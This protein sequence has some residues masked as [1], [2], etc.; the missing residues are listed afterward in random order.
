[1]WPK[2]QAEHRRISDALLNHSQS[3]RALPGITSKSA[4]DTLAM[5]FIA[6]IRR[7]DYY[8]LVQR[9]DVDASK[10]DPNSG[11]FD[12]ERA[13]TYHIQN[14]NIEEAAWLIF[15]MTE[16]ARPASGWQRL[17]DVYGK[18]GTGIWDWKTVSA[19]PNA[20]IDWLA[21]NW[22][23]IGGKFGNHRKY[24]SLRP[25]S[26]RSFEKVLTSY[27]KWIGPHGHRRFFADL[28]RNN[29]NDPG[30]LF[31][32]LYKSM[33]V[34]TFGR[35]ARFDYLS[36]IGRYGIAP[37]EASSAYLETATGPASGVRLLF[38]GSRTNKG[39]D[40]QLQFWL[41]ALDKDLKVGMAVMEDA[42]CN[43][44]KS[45]SSFVHYKG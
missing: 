6:S 13:V 7:E 30:I 20:M 18:L 2:R 22:R 3:T 1:M 37:I 9:K 45:P 21:K 36:L 44:Q 11:T 12:T 15:L 34:A 25:N 4:R 27:L 16:F 40:H 8:D 39:S 24:E 10:A 28:V 33:R 38:L 32:V 14:N 29:G 17:Q 5:Q 42:L 43:W 26:N 19:N 35:L 23:R 31:D 41:D